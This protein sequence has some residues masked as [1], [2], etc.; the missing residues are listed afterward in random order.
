ML[1]VPPLLLTAAAGIYLLSG[2][3][4]VTV[5]T[6]LSHPQPT[7]IVQDRHG[8]FLTE[9]LEEYDLLG[10]WDMPEVLP[11]KIT[12]ALLATEDKRFYRHR[13][14][15][16]KSVARALINNLSSDT[17]QGAS[18]LAMQ[19][20]RLQDPAPRTVRNKLTETF[21]AYA[22]ISTFGH[23]AVLRH[24]MRI[25]P[26]GH[27]IHGFAYAAR[28]YFRKPVADLSWS[29]SALL[30]ALPQSPSRTDLFR[31]GGFQLAKERAGLILR[32]LADAGDIDSEEYS[33]SLAQ[34]GEM[35]SPVRETRPE[36]A[37]H[38]IQRIIEQPGFFQDGYSQ[39]VRSTLDLDIQR[40]VALEAR[41]TLRRLSAFGAKNIAAIVL[42][43]ST[44]EILAYVG[45]DDYFDADASGSINYASTPRSSGS[46]LK[47]FLYAYG[48]DAKMFTSA[49]IIADIPLHWMDPNGEYVVSNFDGLY[50]GPM[51][52]GN[53]LAN[54]RNI[55]AVRVLD[56]L[57]PDRVFDLFREFGFHDG[58]RK[59]THYGFGMMLG[60]LYVTLEDLMRA[61]GYLAAD[62]AD[63]SLK[64]SLDDG[65]ADLEDARGIVPAGLLGEDA[66]RLV[67]GYLSDPTRRLPSFPRLSAL[68][69]RFP[70]A[71]KTGTSQGFRDAWTVGYSGRYVI[72]AW[73]GDPDNNP[74]NHVAGSIIAELV[75][76]LF[77]ILEPDEREGFD[78]LPFP[79]PRDSVAVEVSNVSGLLAHADTP[80]TQVEHFVAGTEPTEYSNTYQRFAVDRRSGKLATPTTP[81][82]QVVTQL[83]PVLP[84]EY[85]AWAAENG[86]TPPGPSNT[87]PERVLLSIR[88]PAHGSRFVMDPTIPRQFQTIGLEVDVEP[89]VSEV[90]WLVDGKEVDRTSFPYTTRWSLEPGDH[91][92]QVK[93]PR[94]FIS[95]SEVIFQVVE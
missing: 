37:L 40:T 51:L 31:P 28:R 23:D 54:S 67:T 13:G 66:I 78:Y 81:H 42:E 93:F 92:V 83:F 88:Y 76:E 2:V 91:R 21:T 77:T 59:W 60:G 75:H 61:Y 41:D 36:H 94:A 56:S 34:L 69:F 49:S 10:F 71:I 14:V 82:H 43:A 32:L 29:E 86:M 74:M 17:V 16:L 38:F 44:G 50:L 79:P 22:L 95:S 48:I 5:R 26:I 18:T 85:S 19:V 30:A 57:G 70:V 39:P 20:A 33:V 3:V 90:I 72:G 12:R 73:T 87:E 62:G 84:V 58:E 68:E 27:Q 15:D 45:S 1:T 11:T 24:Y 89:R 63:F 55:A 7:P 8:R 64:W 47:P 35:S 46:I 4:T 52:Y 9:G 53:A 25:V 6:R 65:G 80:H